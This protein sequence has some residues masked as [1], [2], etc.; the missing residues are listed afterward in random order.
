[1]AHLKQEEENE[2]MHSDAS[3]EGEGKENNI[4]VIK[5]A[6]KIGGNLKATN[7][8]TGTLSWKEELEHA[9]VSDSVANLCEYKCE[10][11]DNTFMSRVLLS[12]H[13]RQTKHAEV[14]YGSANNNLT[15]IVAYKCPI[16]SRKVLCDKHII[17]NHARQ[18]HNICHLKEYCR[19]A[20]IKYEQRRNYKGNSAREDNNCSINKALEHAMVSDS[21]ADLCQYRCKNC[22][23]TFSSRLLLARHL[24]KTNHAQVRYGT[25]NNYLTNVVA[26]KCQLCFKRILC[27]KRTVLS[28]L[29]QH[30]N[31]STFKEYCDKTNTKY[32]GRKSQYLMEYNLF[33]TSSTQ[34][35]PTTR[36]ED[37]CQF[38]CVSCDFTCLK[39]RLMTKHINTTGHGSVLSLTKYIASV[40]FHKCLVCE[41]LVPSDY[42]IIAN[43]LRIHKLTMK[44]YKNMF[45][46]SRSDNTK[47]KVGRP[48]KSRAKNKAFGKSLLNAPISNAISNLCEYKC[49]NCDLTFPSKNSLSYH[50]KKSKHAVSQGKGKI[51]NYLTKTVA[52]KCTVC[53]RRVLCDSVTIM[54]HVWKNHDIHSL[55]EYSEKFNLEYNLQNGSQYLN[56]ALESDTVSDCIKNLCEYQ[57]KKCKATF[58]SRRSLKYHFNITKHV[59]MP[60]RDI[61]NFLIKVVAHKC[62]VCS[63]S[64]LCDLEIVLNHVKQKHNISSL[65]EYSEMTNA[66]YE[67]S[68]IHSFKDE[69]LKKYILKLKSVIQ[70]I[71]ALQKTCHPFHVKDNTIPEDQTTKDVGN[72]SFF[73]CPL[74]SA[75]DMSYPFLLK[76]FKESHPQKHVSNDKGYIIQARYHKCH[77][78]ANLVLCDNAVI[79]THLARSHKLKMS[80]YIKDYVLK[81]GNKVYPTFRD[82]CCDRQVFDRMKGYCK[83]TVCLAMQDD[84]DEGDDDGFITP[85]MISS[86]SEDSDEVSDS[87]SD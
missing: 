25:L 27:D 76:H 36:V 55:K 78:C 73:K 15:K 48:K 70:D 4:S 22:D 8:G 7:N 20:K 35:E 82:Y 37:L 47:E 66:N 24:K 19:K 51:N 74:C 61:N 64:I 85:G 26:H 54:N 33:G 11:C 71:P 77:I 2:A 16:C 87:D 53:Q 68:G 84:N 81:N 60:R 39:W 83:D 12:R 72:I 67:H 5:Q 10:K 42:H 30:H 59:L 79:T 62:H 56:K 86:E 44:T 17:S 31:I 14:S 58:F 40:T 21:V 75:A 23:A 69:L 57:C 6:G 65:K 28:H 80:Q 38:K 1:M 49:P 43:H 45:N 18:R 32:K 63:R 13:L 9:T 29:I 52:H 41:E 3:P 50:F 34:N 46:I